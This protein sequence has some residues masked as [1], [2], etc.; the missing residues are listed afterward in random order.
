MALQKP[1]L[2]EQL[3]AVDVAPITY[4]PFTQFF[5]YLEDM[6]SVDLTKVKTR[7]E[8]DDYLKALIP[9]CTLLE[10]VNVIVRNLECVSFYL[11]IW[12][13]RM[14]MLSNGV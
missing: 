2:V 6:K 8:A 11:P 10:I 4:P 7:K 12:C 1:E 9:V 3:V 5:K 14:L 13:Q